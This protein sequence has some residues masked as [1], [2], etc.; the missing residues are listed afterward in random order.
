MK[1]I[2]ELERQFLDHWMKLFKREK[3]S[4]QFAEA[5]QAM[6]RKLEA[7]AAQDRAL[8]AALASQMAVASLSESYLNPQP[9]KYAVA[10]ARKL[11]RLIDEG[12]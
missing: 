4:A 3:V 6:H 2:P 8:I 11:L 10:N 5:F 9:L 1:G 12:T 7:Y